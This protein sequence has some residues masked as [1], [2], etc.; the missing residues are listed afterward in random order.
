[1]GLD[2]DSMDF[3][4]PTSE[5]NKKK[6]KKKLLRQ[7]GLDYTTSKGKQVP[8]KVFE[9]KNCQC[10]KYDCQQ[11]TITERQQIHRSF[12]LQANW[13]TQTSFIINNI[14]RTP[15]KV[16]KTGQ[17]VSRRLFS[18]SYSLSGIKVCQSTF[19]STLGISAKRV[20]YAMRVKQTNGM[21]LPD[22]KGTYKRRKDDHKINEVKKFL[23]SFPHFQS[24]YTSTEN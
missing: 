23:D 3:P 7:R 5:T 12:W 21:C 22:Q 4:E 9:F 1:M 17:R 2:E 13:Q 18:N 20:D 15:T 11:L 16:K 14:E 6:N 10:K 19:C 8:A 24:H